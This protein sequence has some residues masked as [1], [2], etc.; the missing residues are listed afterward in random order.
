[1]MRGGI[2]IVTNRY[3]EECPDTEANFRRHGIPFDF[4][5]CRGSQS[6]KESRWDAVQN[7][8]A[9]A[10]LPNPVYGSWN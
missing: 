8:T 2:A 3:L 1:M 6:E 10:E 4:M 9:T 7:G 5:M